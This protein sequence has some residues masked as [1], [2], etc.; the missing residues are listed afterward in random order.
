[1]GGELCRPEGK[2][3]SGTEEGFAA[4]SHAAFLQAMYAL[5]ALC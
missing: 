3:V 1:M 2:A 4:E 5:S